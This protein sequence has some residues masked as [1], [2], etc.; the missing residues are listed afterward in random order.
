[1]HRANILYSLIAINNIHYTYPLIIINYRS[2]YNKVEFVFQINIICL[3]FI[4]KK[5]TSGKKKKNKFNNYLCQ[6]HGNRKL[7]QQ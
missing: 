4:R 5:G 1:M 3:V 7:P 6:N 2:N